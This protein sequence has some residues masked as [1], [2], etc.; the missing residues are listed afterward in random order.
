MLARGSIQ[1]GALP[2]EGL[3]TGGTQ[4]LQRC[5]LAALKSDSLSALGFHCTDYERPNSPKC[6]KHRKLLSRFLRDSQ[7]VSCML[8][9]LYG[10]FK[11]AAG[12]N[13][14]VATW[15]HLVSNH[16]V[17]MWLSTL[18]CWKTYNLL[19]LKASSPLLDSGHPHALLVS[20]MTTGSANNGS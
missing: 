3:S 17:A 6:S 5:F 8:K 14:H 7:A 4:T 20:H 13:K 19:N 10:Q 9:K 15:K 11:K 18:S 16:V 1:L 2:K 12:N